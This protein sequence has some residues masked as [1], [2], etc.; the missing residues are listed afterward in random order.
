[1]EWLSVCSV[2][3]KKCVHYL[4]K[5]YFSQS[6]VVLC[7][8][9]WARSWPVMPVYLKIQIYPFTFSD[10]PLLIPQDDSLGQYVCYLKFGENCSTD[11]GDVAKSLFLQF[12][13]LLSLFFVLHFESLYLKNHKRYIQV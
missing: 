6:T 2:A 1:M 8:Y 4:D 13:L 9:G 5:Q 11:M 12:F 7:I 3:D 10:N